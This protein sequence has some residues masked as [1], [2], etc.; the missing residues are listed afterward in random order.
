MRIFRYLQNLFNKRDVIVEEAEIYPKPILCEN[1]GKKATRAI[2]QITNHTDKPQE[3][4]DL[5][6]D[7]HH[8]CDDCDLKK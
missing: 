6:Q 7:L 1:C 3:L 8:L 2:I 5:F 4:R